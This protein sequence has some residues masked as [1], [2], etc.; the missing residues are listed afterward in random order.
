LTSW[1]LAFSMFIFLSLA[2]VK[3]HTELLAERNKGSTTRTR[4]R[5]Y[6]ASDLEIISALGAAS[7]Y[8]SVMV[9]ALY[10]N[11]PTTAL[12]YSHPHIIWLAC[13][14]MLFWIS[15]IWILAHRGQVHDDPVVFAVRDRTSLVTGMILAGVFWLAV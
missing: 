6:Y 2:L 13:P 5:G 7:G 9:L 8:L 1:I 3:R 12:L 11:E 4:G 15:R 14:L 10:I